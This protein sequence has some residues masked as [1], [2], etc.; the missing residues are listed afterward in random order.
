MFH[1]ERACPITSM[2]TRPNIILK[3]G[4]VLAIEPMVNAGAWQVKTLPDGWT[5]K[6][7]DGSLSAI[8]KIRSPSQR[9]AA[10]F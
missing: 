2:P 9:T 10:R 7:A 3:K 8:L 1:E 4:M 6:T 5:V